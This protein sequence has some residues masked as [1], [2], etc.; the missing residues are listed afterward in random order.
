[1]SEAVFGLPRTGDDG[2]LKLKSQTTAFGTAGLSVST[3]NG[4]LYKLRVLNKAAATK[5]WVQIFDKAT[6]PVNT[7]VPIWEAQVPALT[8]YAEDFGLFGLAVTLGLGIAL[9]TTAGVLTLAAA[10]DATAYALYT[11]QT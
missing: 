6:A 1:M 2:T 8:D 4:R 5:Y 3:K 7:D 10:N 11:H 9:S